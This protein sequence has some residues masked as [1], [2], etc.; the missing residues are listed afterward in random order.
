[1]RCYVNIPYGGKV[2]CYKLLPY[3][4]FQC[5]ELSGVVVLYVSKVSSHRYDLCGFFY[6]EKVVISQRS[7]T[8][9]S[10]L[11]GAIQNLLQEYL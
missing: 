2:Y 3:G 4:S 11:H 10:K 6:S 7:Y 9:K 1:M 5:I 8:S